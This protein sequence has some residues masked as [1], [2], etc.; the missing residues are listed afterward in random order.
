MDEVIRK[1]PVLNIVVPCYNEEEIL[2]IKTFTEL[3]NL[4]SELIENVEIHENS[5]VV[6]IDDGSKDNSWNLIKNESEK[7]QYCQGVKL[8][9]NKGHQNALLAGLEYSVNNSADIMVSIDADLQDDINVIPEMIKKYKNGC[10]IVYG[11]RNDRKTDSFLKKHTAKLFYKLMIALGVNL[12]DNHADFRLMDSLVVEKLLTFKE[13]NLFLRAI[14]PEIGY[15]VDYVYYS[16]LV[17]EAGESK[18]PLKK[19]ISFALDGITSFSIKPVALITVIG[20]IVIICSCIAIIYSLIGHFLGNTNSGWTSLFISIWFLGGVQ[21][22][23]IGIVGTYIGKIYI[24]TKERPRFIIEK[25]T[26]DNS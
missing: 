11:V 19:M 6:Y 20:L 3:T 1:K 21:L 25:T 8:S 5:T 14:V 4:V 15:K 2:T 10:H 24:E 23:S 12:V 17:R 22:V 16:R 9:K 26:N 18:Y 13:R 7:N